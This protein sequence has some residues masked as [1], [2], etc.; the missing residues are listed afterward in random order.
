M[1]VMS[2]Y[3]QFDLY[4]YTQRICELA[5]QMSNDSID[6]VTLIE[7]TNSKLCK[8]GKIIS[9]LRAVLKEYKKNM[10]QIASKRKKINRISKKEDVTSSLIE[11]KPP[12]LVLDFAS[13]LKSLPDDYRLTFLM[14]M[15][16]MSHKEVGQI[17]KVHAGIGKIRLNFI[18]KMV[19]KEFCNNQ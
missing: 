8:E 15:S 7:E 11:M 14:Y 9:N 19:E 18:L 4:K 13:W 10:L 1:V 2:L 3:I 16:G 12:K 5:K 6:A 17:F